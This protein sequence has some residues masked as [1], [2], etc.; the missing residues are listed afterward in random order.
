MHNDVDGVKQSGHVEI[1]SVGF[2]P[3]I[4]D[5]VKFCGFNNQKLTLIIGNNVQIE[6]DVRIVGGGIVTLSDNITLHNHVSILGRGD[7]FIGTN[8][9][10]AQYTSLDCEGG[11]E[12]GND[13]CI[14]YNCQIWSHVCRVPYLENMRFHGRAKT[15][16][17]DR[18]WLQGGLITI[19]PGVIIGEDCVIFSQSV[20]NHNTLPKKVYGGIPA[21]LIEKFDSPYN[22]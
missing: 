8:T 13:C 20:V 22:E 6:D 12:I 9:W 14:G 4:G 2:L 15:V 1:E 11:L 5:N 10:V 7:C 16:L 3:Q 17:K 21:K 19:N 18:V